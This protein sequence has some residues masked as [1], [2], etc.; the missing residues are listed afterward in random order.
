[1]T[2]VTTSRERLLIIVS[3][4]LAC[5]AAVLAFGISPALLCAVLAL[6]SIL[7][8]VVYQFDYLHPTVA[9][10]V[11]WQGII[12]VS[13]VPI[14]RNAR[15][16]SP[17]TY[18]LILCAMLVWAVCTVGAPTRAYLQLPA[19][20]R[21][22]RREVVLQ[23]LPY[24]TY[25]FVFLY[26][27]AGLNV[28]YSGYIP[29][30]QLITTGNSEYAD[31]GLP[32]LY[33]FFFAYANALGCL[34][35]YI[36]LKLKQRRYLWLFLSVAVIHVAFVT[37]QHLMTLLVEAFVIRC[38]VIR[39]F[40]QLRLIV[41]AVI[42]LSIFGFIG[43]V[44]SGD[45]REIVHAASEYDWIPTAV[46]WLYAYSY[47]NILNLENTMTVSDAP[48]FDG[49]MLQTILPSVLRPEL[50]HD[51]VF[52][53]PTLNI[54][55]YIYPV[56]LDIGTAG[57]LVFTGLIGFL[58]SR[59]YA[60]A[61]RSRAFGHIAAYAFFYYAAILSFFTAFWLYLP[62]VFQVVFFMLFGWIFVAPAGCHPSSARALTKSDGPEK[63]GL[64]R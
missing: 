29:I 42:A 17:R 38:F 31:F 23:N 51:A 13:M 21:H 27:L 8:L 58:T 60:Q 18:G 25:G 57:V 6:I 63:H 15:E 1:M 35:F 62:V 40:G 41:I 4:S 44:R 54:L 24:V 48:Y 11:P 14:S 50:N 55:S 16:L 43:E 7:L 32:S 36:H 59:A 56:Y 37:R 53:I 49:T 12:A 9:F 3:A 19:V 22:Q 20:R 52:E 34:S 28:A 45:I 2:L 30:L 10:I 61:H 26:L 5:F 33:G 64:P 47:F 46:V 39:P